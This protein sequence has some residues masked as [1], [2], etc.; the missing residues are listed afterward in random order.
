MTNERERERTEI[1]TGPKRRRTKIGT[2]NR[3][4]HPREETNRETKDKRLLSPRSS[5]ETMAADTGH[6]SSRSS[7]SSWPSSTDAN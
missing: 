5:A 4:G 3:E 2:T 7:A 1:K 6:L